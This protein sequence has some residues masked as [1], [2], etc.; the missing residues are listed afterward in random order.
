MANS[1][2]YLDGLLNSVQTVREDVS[3]AEKQAERKQ[4]ERE[5]NRNKISPEDDFMQASGIDQFTPQPQSYKNLR[6]AFSEDDF[7]REFEEEL[8]TE[9]SADYDD[10]LREF[11]EE[12]DADNADDENASSSGEPDGFLDNLDQI[13]S[14]AK[15]QIQAEEKVKRKKN[16][17]NITISEESVDV[18]Q[19]QDEETDTFETSITQQEEF[20][21]DATEEASVE[22]E[23]GTQED[24]LKIADSLDDFPDLGLQNEKPIITD[25][26]ENATEPDVEDVPEL[27]IEREMPDE[28]DSFDDM[29]DLTFMD[30]V[31]LEDGSEAP[32][33]GDAEPDLLDLLSGDADLND[34]SSLLQADEGNVTLDE[35]QEN[36]DEQAENVA[37]DSN[38]SDSTEAKDSN[39]T[40]IFDRIKKILFS[41]GKTSADEEEGKLLDITPEDQEDLAQENME[42]LKAMEETEP[43]ADKKP[44]KKKKKEKKPK[45]PKQPKPKKEKKPKE[46]KPKKERKPDTSPKIPTK[47]IMIFLLLG[48][49]IVALVFLGQK[50][51]G[52]SISTNSAQSAYDNGDYF[53]AYEELVGLELDADDEELF[54]KSRLLADLQKREREYN[55]F[56]S[57]EDYALALDA[58]IMGVGSYNENYAD[59]EAYG[60]EDV[61]QDLGDTLLTL[62]KDQFGIS[63]E[64][65]LEIYSLNR[66]DYSIRINEIIKELGLDS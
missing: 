18:S 4:L 49:S 28:A 61:Y 33:S 52:Y 6:S 40:S 55:V 5:I 41:K 47:L 65:A 43:T 53:S 3:K 27:E 10:F 19:Q 34:I 58:L 56:I 59:A 45:E 16:K 44:E 57:Q 60:V 38:V 2:D 15:K 7:L 62:L 20:H 39:K 42:I 14:Q 35:A 36:F 30:D 29:P 26:S 23:S 1:E 48:L 50:F 64:E 24:A 17:N 46:P 51:L 22:Y 54:A 8:A 63:E 9:D 31:R 11:E 32:L 66:E 25:F 12:L 37:V 21:Q 13:I